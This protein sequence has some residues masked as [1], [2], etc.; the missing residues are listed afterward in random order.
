MTMYAFALASA[1][2]LAPAFGQQADGSFER[3]LTVSG[4]VELDS[5]TDSGGIVVTPGPAGS[6]KIRAILKANRGSWNSGDV[7]SRIRQIEQNPPIEQTG[8]KIRVGYVTDHNLLKG[9]SMRLEIQ[10]P[11]ETRLHAQA[12][13]GGIRVSGIKGP[14]NCQT[15]SGGIEANQ[16]GSEVRAQADSGGIHV[17]EVQG[18]VFARADSGG[19]EAIGVAGSLDVETDSGGIRI[20]QTQAGAIR[21]RADSGGANVRLASSAGYNVSVSSSSGR[22][23]VPDLVVNGT[24][25]RNR[26]EGKLRGGGPLVDVHVSSGSVSVE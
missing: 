19:I 20:E 24:I 5:S 4:P 7:L 25:S 1:I 10:T 23:S 15:D 11:P 18:P 6:V 3:S 17:R 9:I 12:D 13:S 26:A 16:I 2:A 21:A 14:V 22:I 8:N